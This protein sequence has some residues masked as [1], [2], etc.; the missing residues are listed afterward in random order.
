MYLGSLY[1]VDKVRSC[2]GFPP[3][4]LVSLL[5]KIIIIIQIQNKIT[6]RKF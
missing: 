1:G 6:A 3:G 4:E 2:H 5:K